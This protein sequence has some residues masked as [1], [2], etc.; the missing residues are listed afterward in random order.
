LIHVN[1]A[2]LLK[3]CSVP[4]AI[5][6]RT[7]ALQRGV[8]GRLFRFRRHPHTRQPD[9]AANQTGWRRELARA[10]DAVR[11]GDANEPLRRRY[12]P[13]GLAA[14]LLDMTVNLGREKQEPTLP[15]PNSMDW[16]NPQRKD[17]ISQENEPPRLR[18]AA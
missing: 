4:I 11:I 1:A 5:L 17:T 18:H 13:R 3:R 16:K 7:R 2:R 15:Y 14:V 9:A 6:R 8:T 10:S 12:R